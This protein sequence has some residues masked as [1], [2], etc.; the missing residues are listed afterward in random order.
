MVKIANERKIG[1]KHIP[2]KISGEKKLGFP[3]PMND[4]MKDSRAKEILFDKKTH[5]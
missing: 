2:R 5:F 4:W 1:E 3:L